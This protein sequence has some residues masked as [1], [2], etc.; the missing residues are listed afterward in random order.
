MKKEKQT[1][2]CVI[3]TILV[4]YIITGLLL[5]LLAFL[6][7]KVEKPDVVAHIGVIVI[8][9]V[10][11][12]LGGYMIGKWKKRQKFLW[13]LLAGTVYVV[14]LLAIGII[15]GMGSLPNPIAALTTILVCMGSGML[16]GMVS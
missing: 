3:K 9:V 16:G 11:C 4:M 1:K 15:I 6:A 7:S 8:Y 12:M 13:G 2:G 10:S 5:I 14:I